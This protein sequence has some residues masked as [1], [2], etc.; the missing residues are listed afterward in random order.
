MNIDHLET[1]L[2]VARLGSFAAVARAHDLD[3]SSVSRAVAQLEAE[4]GVRLFQ[5]STRQMELT[6]AGARYRGRIAPVLAELTQAKEEA[7]QLNAEP[8]G[9]V[10]MT[11]S[12]AFG[13]TCLVP[14]L[15]VLGR[16]YPKLCIELLLSDDNIDLIANGVDLAIRLAPAID[17]DLIVS[18]LM[19]TRYRVVCGAGWQARNTIGEDPI[20]L[21]DVDC[22]RFALPDYRTQW[23]FRAPGGKTTTVP[24]SGSVVISSALA[25]RDAALADLGPALLADWLVTED[26]KAGRLVDLFPRH[27]VAATDFDTAAWLV[28]PSRNFL[29]QKVRAIIDLLRSEL[30]TPA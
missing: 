14:L 19:R 17:A 23:M 25:L 10:R 2:K 22:L 11:A 16:A 3:P 27:D 4:L 9:T 13:Q 29:P 30:R 8:A 26:L 20:R 1:F 7:A 24:V 28:Y 12:V 15:G 21:S 5:R 6:E 18:K